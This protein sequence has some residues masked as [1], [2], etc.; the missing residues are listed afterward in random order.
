VT[1]R[2]Q[3]RLLN[4]V[5]RNPWPRWVRHQKAV[6]LEPEPIIAPSDAG[7]TAGPPRSN[8]PIRWIGVAAILALLVAASAFVLATRQPDAASKRDAFATMVEVLRADLAGCSAAASSA[9]SDW[10]L[11]HGA[12]TGSLRA[13]REAQTA[14]SACSPSTNNRIFNL[15][16]YAVPSSLAG[17]D[18]TYAVSCLGVWAQEDVGPAMHDEVTLLHQ[19]RDAGVSAAYERLA[20]WAAI[21]LACAN[22]T[23]KAAANR[24]GLSRFSTIKLVKLAQPGIPFAHQ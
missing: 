10:Q 13:E 23:L 7:E 8:H 11:A 21:N 14:A 24:L 2:R 15:T 3:S 19:P 22:S 4:C 12:S 5:Q 20:G 6:N 1:N 16:L 9:I 17:L 18:L